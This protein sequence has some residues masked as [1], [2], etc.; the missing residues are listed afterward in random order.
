MLKKRAAKYRRK[1]EV[2]R[3]LKKYKGIEGIDYVECKICKK[4]SLYIDERHLKTRHNITKEEYI[5]KFPNACL[6]STK[7]SIIQNLGL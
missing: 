7:K 4:R 3:S 5:C 6:V 2:E 1:H